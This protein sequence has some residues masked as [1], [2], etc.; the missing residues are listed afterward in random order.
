MNLI[1]AALAF[2]LIFVAIVFIGV[3]M[4]FSYL[5]LKVGGVD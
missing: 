2:P 1:R 5:A 3:A 4:V